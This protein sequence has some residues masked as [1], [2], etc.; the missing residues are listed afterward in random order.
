MESWRRNPGRGILK[1]DSLR[2]N[3]R[4]GILEGEVWK[5]DPRKGFGGTSRD[6]W[7]GI[8]ESSEGI[9]GTPRAPRTTFWAERQSVL[10]PLCFSA[11]S[12]AT[13]CFVCTGARQHAPS[14][15]PVHKS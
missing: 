14:T 6:L 5:K 4:G 15:A 11:E 12:G 1:K 8:Q 3:L 9:W 7:R 2:R 13:E 10:K